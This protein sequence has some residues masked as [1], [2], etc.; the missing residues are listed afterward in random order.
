M[1]RNQK[2]AALLGMVFV[3][4]ALFWGVSKKR[5]PLPAS[6]AP[7][8]GSPAPPPA[9]LMPSAKSKEYLDA[10]GFKFSYPEDLIL[11]DAEIDPTREYARLELTSPRVK[12]GI[13]L[14]VVDSPFDDLKGWR[15]AVEATVSGQA[16][17]LRVADLQA[18]EIRSDDGLLTAMVDQGALFTIA[19]DSQSQKE[20]WARAYETL[21]SSLSFYYPEPEKVETAPAAPA[22]DSDITFLGEEIIE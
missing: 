1:S 3:I 19:V 2:A 21:I 13:S 22:G 18:R 4:G 14:A 11:K 9:K 12:G 15:E 17:D 20:F 6:P 5:R 10:S 8:A 7:P 16:R